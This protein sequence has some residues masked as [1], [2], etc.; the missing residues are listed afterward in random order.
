MPKTPLPA[1]LSVE[2]DDAIVVVTISREH[3]R[4]ALDDATVRGLGE[5]FENLPART[6]WSC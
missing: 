3:K 4:N 2:V 1:S 5:V 6:R